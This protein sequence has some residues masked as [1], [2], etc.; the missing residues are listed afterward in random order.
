MGEQIILEGTDL[1]ALVRALDYYSKKGA[2]R[3][4]TVDVRQR[5]MAYKVNEN[6]WT[7]TIG[8]VRPRG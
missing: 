8:T 6:M 5:G 2:L 1:A 4:L 7:P 3:S